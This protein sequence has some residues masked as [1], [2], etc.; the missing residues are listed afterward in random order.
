M[1]FTA[2]ESVLRGSRAKGSDR[3]ILVVIAECADHDG[4]NAYP[5]IETIAE[6][7]NVNR[8]TVFRAIERLRGLGELQ[9]EFKAGPRGCNLYTVAICDGRNGAENRRNG[10]P[11]PSQRRGATVRQMRPEPSESLIEPSREPP[12]ERE[13][14]R[15]LCEWLT[16]EADEPVRSYTSVQLEAAAWLIDNVAREELIAAVRWAHTRPFWASRARTAGRLR[17]VWPDLRADWR[18]ASKPQSNGRRS[19]GTIAG[20]RRDDATPYG[21]TVEHAKPYADDDATADPKAS[22]A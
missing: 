19:S 14:A 16:R 8:A 13:D 15:K 5:A 11:E 21:S 3:M 22:S 18:A 7:A 4:A 20:I 6:R 17:Q 9:V 2:V 1:S 12:P 10:A